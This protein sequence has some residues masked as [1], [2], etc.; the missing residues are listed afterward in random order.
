MR[1]CV[2][3][4]DRHPACQDSCEKFL[5]HKA[6]RDEKLERI[7]KAKASDK[8]ARDTAI[9]LYAERRRRYAK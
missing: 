7:R 2:Q 8:L 4:G 1:A 6:Q 9:S 5:E 3:C